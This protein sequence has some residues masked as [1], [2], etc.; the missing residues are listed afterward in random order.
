MYWVVPSDLSHQPTWHRTHLVI[1]PHPNAQ[2]LFE[3]NHHLQRSCPVFTSN[4]QTLQDLEHQQTGITITT[5]NAPNVSIAQLMPLRHHLGFGMLFFFLLNL[6]KC[7]NNY[8]TS[9]S[10]TWWPVTWQLP[11]VTHKQWQWHQIT[12]TNDAPDVSIAQMTPQRCRLGF[13]MFF[14]FFFY[15]IYLNVPTTIVLVL[16]GHGGL[17]HG[18]HHLLHTNDNNDD[19]EQQWWMTLSNNDEWHPQ[20][21]NSPNDA[22][23]ALF[24][25]QY[26]FFSIKFIYM[27]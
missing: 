25:L 7:T 1:L 13:S 17:W 26:V 15:Q 5:N 14:F 6:F 20:H 19:T 16:A 10:R 8:S 2:H 11:P 21:L 24:G 27:Y 3:H 23:E 12:M 22:F 18:S 4:F 9:T